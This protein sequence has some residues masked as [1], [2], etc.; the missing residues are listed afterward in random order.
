MLLH[1]T[2]SLH[3]SSVRVRALRGF[4]IVELMVS[5]V[6]FVFINAV[7]LVRH[8]QFNAQI[9]LT[10]VAYEVGLAVREAQ[11]YGL[12]VRGASGNFSA[13]YGVHFNGG[14]ATTLDSFQIF[15]D[16]PD[17]SNDCSP[18]GGAGTSCYES[19]ELL[20][21]KQMNGGYTISDFCI[22]QGGS[23][24]CKN[25]DNVQFLDIVFTRP[26]PDAAIRSN[27]SLTWTSTTLTVRSRDG[28]T[29]TVTVTSTGQITVQ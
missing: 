5:V 10:N 4:T 8:S 20:E 16:F 26:N 1:S 6:I 19:G 18:S 21:H 12:G 11:V 24:L 2:S 17:G 22:T 7:I 27:T 23:T 14:S 3:S 29:R 15:R 9:L 13:S 25:A 28:T